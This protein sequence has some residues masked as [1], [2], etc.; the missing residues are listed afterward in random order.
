MI[1]HKMKDGGLIRESLQKGDIMQLKDWLGR[2]IHRF[3]AIYAPKALQERTFG[4]AYNPERLL[5]YFNQ[6]F[7]E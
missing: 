1:W 4:E 7:L 6:K 5:A 3:G 2:N